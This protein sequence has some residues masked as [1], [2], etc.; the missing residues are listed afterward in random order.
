M[1]LGLGLGLGLELGFG[2]FK[3]GTEYEVYLYVGPNWILTLIG[4]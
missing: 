4:S 2:D 3:E 1:R